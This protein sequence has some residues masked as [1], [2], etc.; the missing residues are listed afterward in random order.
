MH[1]RWHRL[2]VVPIEDARVDQLVQVTD[3]HALGDVGDAAAE[4]GGPHGAVAQA[5]QDGALP[6]AIDDRQ[7]GVDGAL[8]ALARSQAK[9]D[10]LRA[11]GAAPFDVSIFDPAQLSRAFVGHD[12]VVNLATALPPTRSAMRTSAWAPCERL[13]TEGSAAVVD[14]ALAAEVPRLVQE[15]VVMIYADGGAAWLTA[16]ARAMP[17]S[18]VLADRGAARYSCRVPPK[19][20]GHRVIG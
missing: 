6:T 14:A 9:A 16:P 1:A 15:S 13:R 8:S 3:Q 12:A 4:F 11:H 2:R 20:V 18:C 10:E 5:P 7:R 19:T 17:R